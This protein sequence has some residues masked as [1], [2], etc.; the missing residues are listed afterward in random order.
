M[1]T[2]CKMLGGSHSYGLQTPESD[3]DY[4]GV[5]LNTDVATVIGLDR[6]EHQDL[7]S[8]QADCFYWELRH[9]LNLLRKGNSQGVE[10]LFNTDWLELDPAFQQLIGRRLELIDTTKMYRCLK[11]YIQGERRLAAGERQGVLGGKRRAAVERYGYSPKNCV[12]LLRLCWAG[13]HFFRCQVFPVN[14]REYEPVFADRLLS[15]KTTPEQFRIAELLLQVDDLEHGMDEAF[16]ELRPADHLCFD[17]DLANQ[18]LV[19]CYLPILQG[20]Q[21]NTAAASVV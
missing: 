3:T 13:T 17:S 4:R 12:Q 6:F 20:F 18:I 11:G 19:D 14:V 10:L 16:D 5:F 2:I 7:K 8:A 1:K 21:T 15:I 9:F